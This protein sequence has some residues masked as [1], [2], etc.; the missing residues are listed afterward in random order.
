MRP[1]RIGLKALHPGTAISRRWRVMIGLIVGLL[2]LVPTGEALAADGEV[3]VQYFWGDGCPHCAELGPRLADLAAREPSVRLEAY[4][5]WNRPENRSVFAEVA[6]AHG[7]EASAVPMTFARGRVWIGFHADQWPE[8][9][10]SIMGPR[11]GDPPAAAAAESIRLPLLG[12]VALEGRSLFAATALVAFVDG[13]NPCSLWVLT[14]LLALALHTRSRRRVI[15]VGATFLTVTTAIYGL[16]IAGVFTVMSYLDHLGWIRWA[17]AALALGF[18]LVNIKDAFRYKQGISLTIPDRFKPWV[19]RQGRGAARQQST[20]GLVATTAGLAGGVALVE[21]PCTAGFPVIWSTMVA[22]VET[23]AF[24]GL[25]GLYLLIYVLDE[26]AVFGAAAVTMRSGKLQQRH[27]EL[28]KL[29]GGVLMLGLALVLVA[30]PDRMAD[31]TVILVLFLAALGAGGVHGRFRAR[32]ARTDT[33]TPP[34]RS[35]ARR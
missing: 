11:S 24:L 27:G 31:P 33:S 28:L 13:F 5:V 34:E 12:E 10:A 3:L 6:S 20:V 9:E 32:T 19:Y 22:G 8:M 1:P 35:K 29:V 26:A 14:V 16:F 7:V 4:E 23:T 17:V 15:I 25:L 18:A 21:L 2:L 30:A